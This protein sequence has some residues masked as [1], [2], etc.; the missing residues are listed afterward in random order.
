[1]ELAHTREYSDH[2]PLLAP[3]ESLHN[4]LVCPCDQC[5]AVVVVE[6]L[7]NILSERVSCS[8]WAYSPSTP[9][10]WITPQQVAHGALMRHLLD[11]VES[12]NVVK[13][14]NGWRKTAVKTEDLVLDQGGEGKVVEKIG[15]VFP[16]VG[17]AVFAQALVVETVHLGN[18]AR[19]VVATEDGDALRIADLKGNE[20]GDGLNG[21]VTSVNVVAYATCQSEKYGLV[22]DSTNP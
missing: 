19:F 13:G 16:H 8:S 2:V 10:I 6:R 15:K 4:Q 11:A 7:T 12:A 20:E 5:Q 22:I 21:E 3:V 9:V 17:V 1:M 14:I 18:L